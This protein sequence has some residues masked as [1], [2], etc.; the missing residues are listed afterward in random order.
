MIVPI[1]LSLGGGGSG[2]GSNNRTVWVANSSVASSA[3]ANGLRY[4]P[5]R[6]ANSDYIEFQFVAERT[7]TL[8][9]VVCYAMS[10][11]EAN[12]ITLRLD[13]LVIS[14]GG[15]PTTAVT[16]GSNFNVSPGSD[17]L[18]HTVTSSN[19]GDLNFSVTAGDLV[20]CKLVRLG[21]SDS[22]SGDMRVI[23]VTV[24]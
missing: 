6:D 9:I 24:G 14:S 18:I 23:E 5:L 19:S 13:S 2:S 21:S 12:A 17:V 15:N 4:I 1:P 3:Y 11:S 16:T 10:S 20:Y 8:E 22:H 7:T